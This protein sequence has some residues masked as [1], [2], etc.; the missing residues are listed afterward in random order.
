MPYGVLTSIPYRDPVAVYARFA[1][2]AGAVLLDSANGF[3]LS[4]IAVR[5][6]YWIT[7]ESKVLDN[8]FIHLASLLTMVQQTTCK[9]H[10]FLFR[11]GVI[12]F[13]GYELNWRLERL[14]QPTLA[15]FDIP[16]LAAGIY[17]SVIIFAPS[18]QQAWVAALDETTAHRLAVQ[19]AS[20]TDLPEVD[21]HISGKWY[22]ETS[23]NT[24]EAKVQRVIDSIVAGDVFQV[25]LSQRFVAS[26]PKGLTPLTLYR[27]LRALA[28]APFAAC[29]SLG[30]GKF[31]LSASPEHFLRV[32]ANGHVK[33]YPI[34]GTSPR[35]ITS[36][37]DAT[38]AAALATS[39]KD[40]AENL[41]IVDLLRSDLSKTCQPG[42]IRVPQLCRVESFTTIHHLVSVI[43]GQLAPGQ[44]AIDLLHGTFP[45][46]SVTGAPKIRA[47]EIISELESCRR[48]P[49]CGAIAWLGQ[50]GAM[51]SS[52]IIRTLVVDGNRVTAHAGG[53]VV[54]DSDPATE[55][56]ETMVKAKPLLM[57]LAGN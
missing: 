29:F 52:I 27:R 56:K 26:M 48:G 8:P 49:Y 21:W 20:T 42:S 31:I 36:T 47:M 50:D 17:D 4:Y 54:H 51:D 3:G 6:R 39:T 5:P 38:M 32:E 9:V 13:L 10:K 37:L 12:C 45:G 15:D 43:E 25:N 1:G 2:E 33:T 16:D 14:P 7:Q 28:P 34:K 19:V 23:R 24:Y 44:T 22:T 40:R 46:G 11:G 18:D 57:S 30:A 41:M 35:G 53:G 55:W